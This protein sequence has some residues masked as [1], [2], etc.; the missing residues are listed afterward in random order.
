MQRVKLRVMS[1]RVQRVN[2]TVMG[3]CVLRVN[4]KITYM[5]KETS[6]VYIVYLMWSASCP[7]IHHTYQ[8]QSYPKFSTHPHV[9]IPI[10]KHMEC[11]EGVSS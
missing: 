4:V 11:M 3:A 9:H 1:A 10:L 2:V 6:V 8:S 5:E 7:L